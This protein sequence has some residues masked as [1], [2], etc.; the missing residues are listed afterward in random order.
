[1]PS[2]IRLKSL[3]VDRSK[4]RERN[5]HIGDQMNTSQNFGQPLIPHPLHDQKE[6][7]KCGNM[8]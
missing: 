1:M 4:E 7:I 5:M 6:K 2:N 3:L 8:Q